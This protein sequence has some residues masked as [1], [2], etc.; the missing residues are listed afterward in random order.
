MLAL[1]SEHNSGRNIVP[2]VLQES[3][4]LPVRM[5]QNQPPCYCVNYVYSLDKYEV[6]L[7]EII[8]SGEFWRA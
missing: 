8:F 6:S 1:W 5:T 7:D 2:P 3:L 4:F